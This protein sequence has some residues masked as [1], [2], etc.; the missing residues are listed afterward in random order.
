MCRESVKQLG[1]EA[2]KRQ[3]FKFA[4]SFDDLAGKT[5]TVRLIDAHGRAGTNVM[6]EVCIDVSSFDPSADLF[7]WAE[8][9]PSNAKDKLGELLVG[10]Q[11]LSK[12]ER[13]TIT[14]HQARDLLKT[15]STDNP[16]AYV[17]VTLIQDGKVVKKR[18]SGVRRNSLSPTWNEAMLFNTDEKSL[19]RTRI[20]ISVMDYDRIGNDEVVGQI[21]IGYDVP[22]SRF[23]WKDVVEGKS[24]LP[25]WIPLGA[26]GGSP[27]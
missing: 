8:I 10:V 18:K 26:P 12:V 5:L 2:V 23:Y 6:G 27:A 14:V 16:D 3:D 7:V 9:D 17:K 4:L 11:Y 24:M 20:E 15:H 21:S 19:R 13:L 22:N 1:G 25:V